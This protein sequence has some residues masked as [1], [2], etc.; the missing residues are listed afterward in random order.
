MILSEFNRRSRLDDEIAKI[1]ERYTTEL[2]K[3]DLAARAIEHLL[4]A[5]DV[6]T[7]ASIAQARGDRQ[8]TWQAISDRYLSE[9]GEYVASRPIE[10][11]KADVDRHRQQTEA[12]DGLADRKS[13]EAERVAALDIAHRQ[14]AEA[15]IAIES[16]EKQRTALDDRW[17]KGVCAWEEAWPEAVKPAERSR[18]IESFGRGA[19]NHPRALCCA[20]RTRR[21]S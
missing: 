3:R 21:G 4:R 6:P 1:S 18:T 11:R 7:D 8:A 16:L 20:P 15:L 14:K 9:G 10:D 5:K 17:R 13:L 2:A 19:R 12:A